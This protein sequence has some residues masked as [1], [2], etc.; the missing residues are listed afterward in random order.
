MG[1]WVS[2]RELK[3]K[4]VLGINARNF[5]YLYRCNPRKL[6]PLADDK[7]FS[8]KICESQNIP[9]PKSYGIIER[10][11]DIR[12]FKDMLKGCPEFVIKPARGSEGR[13]IL[14]ITQRDNDHFI[15]ANGHTLTFAEIR[16]HISKSWSGLYSLGGR[17][18]RV[19]IEERIKPHPLFYEISNEGTSDIRIIAHKF[20]PV[21]AMV[22]LPTKQSKGRANLFQGAVAVG[23]NMKTGK[24]QG[25][26][27]KS[28]SIT[29]HPD[30]TAPLAGI[31]I[32]FWSDMR[33]IATKL[34]HALGLA[35]VGIDLILDV[36]RGPLV[37]E[38]NARPG[39]DIQIANQCGLKNIL[40]PMHNDKNG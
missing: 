13:G 11:G 37:L 20:Y 34:S 35:Y 26:V 17:Q 2:P 40:E 21:M 15:Q 30:T 18:D 36:Q 16:Y 8:K 7:S 32:P 22:R 10:Y 27:C 9:V 38:V 12:K 4:S 29:R 5:H 33:A 39:L 3:R 23:I 28:K 6:Y 25:G 19:I 14:I 31:D 24:T 1:K